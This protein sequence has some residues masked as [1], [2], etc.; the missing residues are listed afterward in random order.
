MT[1][2]EAAAV[3][4]LR[5]FLAA[6]NRQ[7]LDAATSYFADDCVFETPRGR[8]PWGRRIHGKEALR[9]ALDRQFAR[10]PDGRYLG[11]EHWVCGSRG[12]SKWTL[13]GTKPDGEPVE[14]WGC[15]LWEFGEGKIVT[16]N[17]FWKIAPAVRD[18]ADPA[19]PP[20]RAHS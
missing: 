19:D 7:D 6:L 8:R 2:Q 4:V 17:S 1:E 16:R 10:F 11:D 12:V 5:N 13:S 20:G 3:E 14:F 15:D 9:V 18:T